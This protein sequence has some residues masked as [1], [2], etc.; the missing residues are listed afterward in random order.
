ML[1]LYLE[2]EEPNLFDLNEVWNQASFG[3]LPVI[4]FEGAP[5]K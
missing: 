4:F 1:E 5:L 2:G 3:F